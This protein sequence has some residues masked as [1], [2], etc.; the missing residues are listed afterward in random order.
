MY[1][2]LI[3]SNMTNLLILFILLNFHVP[4]NIQALKTIAVLIFTETPLG[5]TLGALPR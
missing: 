3:I 5:L 1:I 2:F 4:K